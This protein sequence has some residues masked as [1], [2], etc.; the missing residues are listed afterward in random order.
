MKKNFIR[1]LIVLF[2]VLMQGLYSEVTTKA[3]DKP[4]D[5]NNLIN[6]DFSQPLISDNSYKFVNQ[7]DVTGWQ[8]T[9]PAGVIEVIRGNGGLH[10]RV[11]PP[12]NATHTFAEVNSRSVAELYQ[13]IKTK[14][15]SVLIWSLDHSGRYDSQDKLGVNIG[16]KNNH[17]QVFNG[18]ADKTAWKHYEGTYIVPEGQTETYFGFE[19]L[20]SRLP[21]DGNYITN[22]KLQVL[23]AQPEITKEYSTPHSDGSVH[24]GDPITYT[25]KATN[26]GDQGSSWSETVLEDIIPDGVSV[27]TEVNASLTSNDLVT[28]VDAIISGNKIL[29]Q[30][31]SVSMG[32][33]LTIKFTS[34][35]LPDSLGK[36]IAN[37]VTGRGKINIWD[38]EK[39]ATAS[40]TTPKVLPIPVKLEKT[41]SN[42]TLLDGLDRV[43]NKLYIGDIL[44]Y[45]IKFK[46]LGGGEIK[47]GVL[48]DYLPDS[49]L[50]RDLGN[51]ELI[52][53]G[54]V[55]PNSSVIYDSSSNQLQVKLPEIP[56]SS[57]VN[58]RYTLQVTGSALASNLN[59][60]VTVEADVI[61]PT[62]ASVVT[63]SVSKIPVL[64]PENGREQV[65]PITGDFGLQNGNLNLIYTPALDFGIQQITSQDKIY[66]AKLIQTEEGK[67]IP[68]FIQIH[69]SLKGPSW[70]LGVSLSELKSFKDGLPL[71]GAVV[72]L[73]NAQLNTFE[74]LN[75][76]F[77]G[78]LS[79]KVILSAGG[80]ADIIAQSNGNYMPSNLLLSFGNTKLNTAEESVTLEVPGASLKV[81]DEYKGILTWKFEDVPT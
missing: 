22:V 26:T 34:T 29:T 53:D 38:E 78:N 57:E 62:E 27:P 54:K 59:N 18:S 48:V 76:N 71:K 28:K 39:I 20:A 16:T 80:P 74:G 43:N 72:E 7:S 68:N 56:A 41:V 65:S 14:P 31:T 30:P 47:N 51:Y 70:R 66:N 79:S 10:G 69:N 13:I 73:K 15:G 42:V 21:G 61:S 37:T 2:A 17:P 6:G 50:F 33:V 81:Q 45:D 67:E 32:D 64:N 58:F 11:L 44:K 1:L 77:E 75:Q 55:L 40:V 60:R 46:N 24:V 9:D 5:S 8:T 25:I 12:N 4:V 23:S 19:A 52:L 3:L 35:V 63:N 36:T 49:K